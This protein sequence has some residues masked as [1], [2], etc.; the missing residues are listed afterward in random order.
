MQSRRI[1]TLQGQILNGL[2]S[3]CDVMAITTRTIGKPHQNLY[4]SN[5]GS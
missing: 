2:V 1:V 5:Q 3:M 4:L